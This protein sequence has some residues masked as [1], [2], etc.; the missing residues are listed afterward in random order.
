[1]LLKRLA[2]IFEHSVCWYSSQ[3]A[4]GPLRKLGPVLRKT[5]VP[6]QKP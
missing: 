5:S 1:L 6:E 2:D 3:H 4:A